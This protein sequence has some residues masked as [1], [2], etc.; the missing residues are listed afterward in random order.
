[1]NYIENYKTYIAEEAAFLASLPKNMTDEEIEQ[2]QEKLTAIRAKR[3]L[4]ERKASSQFYAEARKTVGRAV[5]RRE[6][7][8]PERAIT[9]MANLD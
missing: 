1:M 4:E 2:A 8:E 3:D 9:G 6:I 7:P 5:L